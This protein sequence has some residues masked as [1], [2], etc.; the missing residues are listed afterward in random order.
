MSHQLIFPGFLDGAKRVNNV[1][2]VIEKEGCVS[3]LIGQDVFFSHEQ[4]DRKSRSFA[5]AS[6]VVNAHARPCEV[7]DVLGVAPRTLI[8]KKAVES[9]EKC[10]SLIK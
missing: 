2:S 4:E 8:L 3:Y 6:L 7:K 10:L 1:V 9:F 5:I